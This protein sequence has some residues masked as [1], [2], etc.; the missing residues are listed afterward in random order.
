MAMRAGIKIDADSLAVDGVETSR[1]RNQR[2]YA[3][4]RSS[5]EVY[6]IGSQLSVILQE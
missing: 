5:I 6:L 1:R 4:V 3:D 2:I